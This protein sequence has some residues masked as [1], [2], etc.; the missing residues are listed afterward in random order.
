MLLTTNANRILGN[1]HA[2]LNSALQLFRKFIMEKR[3][4]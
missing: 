4:V 3:I 2:D 1:F